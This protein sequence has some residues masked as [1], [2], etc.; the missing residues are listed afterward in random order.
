MIYIYMSMRKAEGRYPGPTKMEREIYNPR[1][2]SL[3]DESNNEYN[4]Q[5]LLMPLVL[6]CV[7]AKVMIQ[8]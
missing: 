4:F 6:Y 7:Y 3:A 1:K 8:A 2:S 5:Q